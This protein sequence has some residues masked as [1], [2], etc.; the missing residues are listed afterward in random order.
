MENLDITLILD[1]LVP[2][3]EYQGSLTDNTK[4]SYDSL[5]W[6]D[7]RPKPSWDDIVNQASAVNEHLDNQNRIEELKLLLEKSDHKEFPS[8]V[9]KEGEDINTIIEQR[10][11]W[12]AEIR[13]LINIDS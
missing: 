2:A 1:F 6:N 7:N 3:A 13:S 8:Y 10:V 4:E 9:A 11:A 5:V 12:R